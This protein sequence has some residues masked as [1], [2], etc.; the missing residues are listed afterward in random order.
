M[1]FLMEGNSYNQMNVI[2]TI[3]EI[4]RTVVAAHDGNQPKI[5]RTERSNKKMRVRIRKL[6]PKETFRLMSI[7]DEDFEKAKNIG[8]SDS[9]LYRQAGNGLIGGKDRTEG[10]VSLLIQHLYKAQYDSKFEC[11]DENFTK[12]QAI[13]ATN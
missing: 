7:K 8:I 9:Q 6:A 1:N 13:N 5:I 11:Y 4:C 3:D 10:C 12:A 2:H